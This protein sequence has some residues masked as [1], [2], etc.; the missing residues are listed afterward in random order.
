MREQITSHRIANQVRMRRQDPLNSIL[1]VEGRTDKRVF[2]DIID[3]DYCDIVYAVYKDKLLSAL[4]ILEKSGEKGVLGIVD[5]DYWHVNQISPKRYS[6]NLL[7]TDS[8]DI[9]TMILASQALEKMLNEY[10]TQ[11]KLQSLGRP[12]REILLE[13]G[14]AIGYIRWASRK[15]NL[16]IDFKFLNFYKFV[17]TKDLNVNANR[18]YKELKT[19]PSNRNMNAAM[20]KKH[21]NGLAKLNAD[22]WNICQGHDL[23]EILTIGLKEIF[24]N[25]AKDNLDSDIV[26]KN[27]RLAYNL[28]NFIDTKLYTSIK[29][30]EESNSEFRI[31]LRS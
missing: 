8:H 29:E 3:G 12:I 13:S 24:G 9:D 5:A 28:S 20:V 23:V 2:T 18:L 25:H 6:T 16:S 4:S 26:S 22:V 19:K 10:A 1:L 27:L 14:T 11:F 21:I 15:Y 7:T 31:L 17:D 30:W